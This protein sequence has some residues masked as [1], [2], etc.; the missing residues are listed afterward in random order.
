MGDGAEKIYG[1]LNKRGTK[2]QGVFASE[3]FVR[4]QSF[5]GYKVMSLS[6][7]EEEYGGFTAVLCFALEGKK[8]EILKPIKEKHIMYSPNIPVYGGGVCDKEYIFKNIDKIQR[9]YDCLADELSKE[10]L[11][12]VLKY[13]I[14]GE[15]EYLSCGENAFSIPESFYMHNKRHIDV[16]A[17]DGD[18]ALE[19]TGY[20]KN[21][22]DI[23]AFEPDKINYKKLIGN[24]SGIRNIICENAAVS[25]R[26]G[27]INVEGKGNR[28]SF[29]SEG[30]EGDIKTVSI[31]TYCRQR[32]IN[33]CGIEVGS[34]KIDAEG[35]DRQVL[36]G[37]VNVIY[38]NRPDIMAAVYHRAGDM[39]DIPLLLRSYDYKY[40]LYLR[41]KD[42][43]PAWD[44]FVLATR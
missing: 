35:M 40:R 17:F 37:A 20:N 38:R 21:Y 18:T 26:D 16:G 29:I 23:V 32:N 15:T 9:L 44:I 28:G 42:Y 22:S 2:I 24:T 3:G 30:T 14:T 4:G 19:Y 34:I 39:F 8:A 36:Q 5:L 41:K 10:I 1:E 12:S 33:E 11:L 43:V 13:N 25:D 31:D 27:L 6:E 7:A